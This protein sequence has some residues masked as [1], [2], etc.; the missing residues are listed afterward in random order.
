MPERNIGDWLPRALVESVLIVASILLALGLDEWQ[1]EQEIAEL[2]ERSVSNFTNE[3]RRN[4]LR[5]EDV[6]AYH[7]GVEQLLHN[8]R[9]SGGVNNVE[10]FRSIMDTIQPVVLTNSAWETAVATGVL[11]RMDFELVSALTLTYNTQQRFDEN[12]RNA[13]RTL[14]SPN[15]LNSLNLEFTVVNATQFV[16]DVTSNEAELSVY[17]DQ[18]LDML[19]QQEAPQD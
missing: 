1:E 5:I 17:Y 4:K 14:M 18:I 7:Q 8:R 2:I 6:S 11:G 12:Y 13:L 9:N 3:I 19:E 10:E 16:A 15:N